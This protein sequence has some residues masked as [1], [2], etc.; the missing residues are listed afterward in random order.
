MGNNLIGTLSILG[1][2]TC[3]ARPRFKIDIG[4]P[5]F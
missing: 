3:V 2:N 1:F 4:Y 5:V